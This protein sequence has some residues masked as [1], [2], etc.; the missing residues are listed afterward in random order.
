[1]EPLSSAKKRTESDALEPDWSGMDENPPRLSVDRTFEV[2]EHY[3]TWFAEP[4]RRV[5]A[6]RALKCAVEFSLRGPGLA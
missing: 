1:M 3:G 2:M 5:V 6:L 4:L